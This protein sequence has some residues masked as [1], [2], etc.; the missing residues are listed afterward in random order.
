VA[1]WR[2]SVRLAEML[3]IDD[4]APL[5]GK[6]PAQLEL[7][8]ALDVLED[9]D[10]QVIVTTRALPTEISSLLPSLVSRLVGGLLVPLALPSEATRRAIVGEL[11]LLRGIA[12]E[13]SAADAL[14]AGMAVSVPELQGCLLYLQTSARL[15]GASIDADRVR[16][17]LA[18]GLAPRVPT[19]RAIAAQSAKHF[20]L[21]VADLRSA[22]RRRAVVLARDVA[23][24]LARQLTDKTLEQIGG[25]FGGRDHT[26]VLHGCRK[27]EEHLAADAE[28]RAA[29]G[30]LR[31]VLTSQ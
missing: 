6:N 18:D 4:L 31:G 1:Q 24:F 21:R 3:V 12:L 11:A 20:S 26:T 15:E 23:M 7:Q 8:Q 2:D 19:L 14:A 27:T 9:R 5:A 25:Y 22:S 30:Q 29:V 17:Y 13:E 10:A 28:L 16:Q